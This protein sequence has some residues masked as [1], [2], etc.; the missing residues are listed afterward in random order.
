MSYW[1]ETDR[2][3]SRHGKGP[4]CGS[5]GEEMFPAD[6]HGRFM[7]FCGGGGLDVVTGF[8]TSLFRPVRRAGK[9]GEKKKKEEEEER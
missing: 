8:S 1:D 4:T 5:C 7:C 3:L 6:D 9:S 2:Y